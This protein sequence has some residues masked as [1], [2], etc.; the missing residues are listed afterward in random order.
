MPL[1]SGMG[2]AHAYTSTGA[3]RGTRR[4]SACARAYGVWERGGCYP[5]F[6]TC[7][8]LNVNPKSDFKETARFPFCEVQ[9]QAKPVFS[10]RSLGVVI[11]S[12]AA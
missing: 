6:S 11:P 5:G 3:L 10:A 9:G 8:R 2:E 12:G 1:C 4:W 7:P